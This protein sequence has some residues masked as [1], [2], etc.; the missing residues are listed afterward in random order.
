MPSATLPCRL[1]RSLCPAA[2]SQHDAAR[3]PQ[4]AAT[5]KK[6]LRP[7]TIAANGSVWVLS[8]P[9]LTPLSYFS[10]SSLS[11]S[12]L[13]LSQ[14][15]HCTALLPDCCIA[16]MPSLCLIVALH[17][18]VLLCPCITPSLPSSLPL[19]HSLPFLLHLPSLPLFTAAFRCYICRTSR[20]CIRI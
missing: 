9:V 17:L 4:P 18:R 14:H 15:T 20:H 16:S 12:G 7:Q 13:V 1:R 19:H 3:D 6:Q 8:F 11:G 5:V 10:A 2:A